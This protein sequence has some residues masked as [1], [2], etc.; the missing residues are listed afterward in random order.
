MP[1]TNIEPKI[2][3]FGRYASPASWFLSKERDIETYPGLLPYAYYL[4]QAWHELDLS[5]VLC[6]DGRPAVYLCAS[7][8]SPPDGKNGRAIACMEPRF[9]SA[10]RFGY[11][12]PR[13]VYSTVKKP[14]KDAEIAELFDLRLSSLIT[15]LKRRDDL[16]P[17]GWCGPLKQA[18]FSNS[19][20]SFSF[21]R[22]RG[23]PPVENLVHT[24][25]G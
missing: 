18:N 8:I 22:D 24:N 12:E 14:E 2:D 25:V 19:T 11:A 20:P 3:E 17:H 16:R 21:K 10:S 7:Q 23:P 15:D 4:R 5:G 13:E 1:N 9:G 6:V